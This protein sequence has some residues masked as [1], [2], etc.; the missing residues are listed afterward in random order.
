MK[1]AAYIAMLLLAGTPSAVLA[2]SSFNGTWRIDVGVLP[3]PKGPFVWLIQGGMYE[4]KSCVPPIRVKADGQD[5]A[6]TGQPYDTISVTI[7]NDRSVREIEKKTGQLVSDET[8]TVSPDG[9][10]ATDEF[11]NWKV[12]MSRT[13]NGPPGSHALSGTWN[14]LKL[15]STSD[16]GLLVTFK[17][18]GDMLSMSRPTGESYRAKLDGTEAPLS[19]D[20]NVSL[21]SVKRIDSTT[22]EETDKRLGVVVSVAR[23]TVA[24]DGKSMTIHVQ[25]VAAGTSSQFIANKQ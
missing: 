6:V 4:C 9:N 13:A 22:I 15:E 19:G 24:H 14:P 18:E 25:D 21:V 5:Q 12:T 2:Q 11:A 10:T 16:R 3:T 1:R 8:L 20:P 17:V 23:L 7:L